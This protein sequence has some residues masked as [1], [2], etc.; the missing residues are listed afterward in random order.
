MQN[1][2]KKKKEEADEFCKEISLYAR[3]QKLALS[4]DQ[5]KIFRNR[6]QVPT[7]SPSR[8]SQHQSF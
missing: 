5:N 3:F 7:W 6:A 1:D 4:F 8:C 2:K